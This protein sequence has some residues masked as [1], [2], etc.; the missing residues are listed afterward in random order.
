MPV[1]IMGWTGGGEEVEESM[2]QYKGLVQ[3]R[4]LGGFFGDI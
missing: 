1:T 2:S 4:G 3:H